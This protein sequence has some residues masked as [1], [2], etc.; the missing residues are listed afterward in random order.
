MPWRSTRIPKMAGSGLTTPSSPETTMARNRS[1]NEYRGRATRNLSRRPVGQ[2]VQFDASRIQLFEQGDRLLE[3]A[4]EHLLPA[5]VVGLDQG[6]MI[7][8]GGDEQV[9][10]L[11]PRSP[12]VLAQVPFG[13][14]DLGQETLHRGRI[15]DQ[16]PVEM[17]RVPVDEHAAQVEDDRR[18]RRRTGGNRRARRARVRRRSGRSNGGRRRCSDRIRRPARRGDRA[19]RSRRARHRPQRGRIRWVHFVNVT[20]A[21]ICSNVRRCEASSAAVPAGT[22]YVT[23]HVVPSRTAIASRR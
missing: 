8:V 23:R 9:D 12:G 22:M 1:K 5:N 16:A 20:V 6:G 19:R 4:A 15:R 18:R 3:G 2:G 14:A 7:G 13:R 21:R 17:P 10:R 11:A